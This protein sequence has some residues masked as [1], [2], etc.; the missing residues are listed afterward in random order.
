MEYFTLLQN[1]VEE[2]QTITGSD[3]EAIADIKTHLRGLVTE[4]D[5]GHKGQRLFAIWVNPALSEPERIR[6]IGHELCHIDRQHLDRYGL[7]H[8][9]AEAEATE[10]ADE[11][12]QRYLRGEFDKWK[13]KR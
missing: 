8:P 12:A 6:T 4:I 11:Y 9:V 5:A 3:A 13:I 7:R 2:W 1:P 10:H